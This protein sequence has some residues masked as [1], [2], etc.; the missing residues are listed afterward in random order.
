MYRKDINLKVGDEVV[1]DDGN[2]GVVTSELCETRV[3]FKFSSGSCYNVPCTELTDLAVFINGEPVTED[4]TL[5][6]EMAKLVKDMADP[7]AYMVELR[8][9]ANSLLARYS[10]GER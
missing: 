8:R 5:L 9:S 10:A 7:F 1:F 2:S 6:D 4:P 3:N